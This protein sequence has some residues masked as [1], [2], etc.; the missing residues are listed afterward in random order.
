MASKDSR[1]YKPNKTNRVREAVG[2][3]V[4]MTVMSLGYFS[5][6]T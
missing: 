3:R 2:H 6:R 1:K 5:C 4:T